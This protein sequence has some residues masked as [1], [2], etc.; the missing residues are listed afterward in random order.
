L[1]YAA[2]NLKV[3]SKI[4]Q[5]VSSI[6]ICRSKDKILVTRTERQRKANA[7]LFKYKTLKVN[8]SFGRSDN[9]VPTFDWQQ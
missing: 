5:R 8:R 6:T 3:N 1:G 2:N 9:S 4:Q 7:S